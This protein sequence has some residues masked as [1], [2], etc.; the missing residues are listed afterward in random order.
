MPHYKDKRKI[1]ECDEEWLK[2]QTLA[3][4]CR[5]GNKPIWVLSVGAYSSNGIRHPATVGPFCNKC[6]KREF[7][8]S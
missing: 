3:P 5:C 8:S 1:S 6:V 7:E 2:R 4:L